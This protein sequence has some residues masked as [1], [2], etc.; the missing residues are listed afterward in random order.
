[1]GLKPS[2]EELHYFLD[3]YWEHYPILP[4]VPVS[5]DARGRLVQTAPATVT[6]TAVEFR[7]PDSAKEALL[8]TARGAGDHLSALIVAALTAH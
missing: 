7:K 5:M 3:K 4:V 2:V 6:V 8:R 1:M